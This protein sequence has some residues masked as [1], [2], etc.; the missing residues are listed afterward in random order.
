[1]V[2]TG[3]RVLKVFIYAA[4]FAGAGVC[5]SLEAQV[6]VN[7]LSGNINLHDP[8]IIRDGS[9]CHVFAS[10]GSC[11]E[12]KTS[13]DRMTWTNAGSAFSNPGWFKTYVPANNGDVW[14]PDISYRSGKYWMYYSVSTFGSNTSAIGL[15]TCPSLNSPAWTDQGMV[16]NSTGSNDYNCIDP[17]AFQDSDGSTWLAF[18]S[19]WTG[20]KLVQVD[21]VTGKPDAA[22]AIYSIATRTNTALG[23]EAPF[24]FKRGSYYYLFV[25]WDFCCRGVNSTYNIRFGRASAVTGPYL[26]QGGTDMASGGGT[27]LWSGDSRWVGPGAQNVFVDGD[28][29][30]L[31]CHAYDANDGGRSKL[32]IRQLYWTSGGWPS[33]T[34][35]GITADR[36]RRGT[37]KAGTRSMTCRIFGDRFVVPDN[38]M[39]AC[40]RCELY[41]I[42]GKLLQRVPIESGIVDLR[43]YVRG[44]KGAYLLHFVAAEEKISP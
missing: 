17:N 28:T 16:V 25:S 31:V 41:G 13:P 26:D 21:S 14:A 35:T 9:T 5:F 10:H 19:F 32:I 8:C 42:H 20:I 6:Y 39:K 1:M 4:A 43:K 22:P 44:V 7:P 11:V 18:G 30:F 40:D 3:K 2:C 36:D 33:L 38:I 34:P 37:V 12:R 27:L 24:L 29:T 15:T 23:I